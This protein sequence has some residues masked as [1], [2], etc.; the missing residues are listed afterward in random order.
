MPNI[1]VSVNGVQ[2]LLSN[3]KTRQGS[4]SRQHQTS[5][6]KRI[7]FTNFSH[8]NTTFSEIIGLRNSPKSMDICKCNTAVQERKQRRPSK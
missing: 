6:S 4:R 7:K 1:T 2:K 8:N 3:L 5:G